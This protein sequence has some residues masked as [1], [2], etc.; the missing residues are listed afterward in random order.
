MYRTL[1]EPIHKRSS[2]ADLPTLDIVNRTSNGRGCI[3]Q[4]KRN[5]VGHLV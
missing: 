5:S 1:A 2:L 4:Q 3:A